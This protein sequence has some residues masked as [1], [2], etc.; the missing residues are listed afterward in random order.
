MKTILINAV[1]DQAHRKFKEFCARNDTSFCKVLRNFIVNT[2]NK[3]PRSEDT[4]V[5]KN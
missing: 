4:L 2:L 3:Y 1:P 5:Y